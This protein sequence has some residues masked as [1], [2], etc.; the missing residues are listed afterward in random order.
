MCL[1]TGRKSLTSGSGM[2]VTS[3]ARVNCSPSLTVTSD[4]GRVNVGATSA[5][6]VTVTHT[7]TIINDIIISIQYTGNLKYCVQNITD[8]FC[9]HLSRSLVDRWG[10]TDDLATSSL[11]SSRLSAFLMAAPSIMPF[12]DV[13]LPSRFLSASSS[14]SLHCALQDCLDK[15]CRSCY[16]PVPFQFA[17]LYCGQEVFVGPNGLLNFVLESFIFI[18]KNSSG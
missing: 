4:N 11:H 5:G 18:T 14:P 3:H 16:V 8:L 2:A 7:I 1:L 9:F 15:P 17:S 13:V 12:R 10:A 6:T